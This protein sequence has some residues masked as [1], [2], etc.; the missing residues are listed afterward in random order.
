MWVLWGLTWGQGY[1]CPILVTNGSVANLQML[2]QLN[3]MLFVLDNVFPQT[4]DSKLPI[5]HEAPSCGFEHL[6][7]C[8]LGGQEEM[9]IKMQI[10]KMSKI[11]FSGLRILIRLIFWTTYF[12]ISPELLIV[13]V[14]PLVWSIFWP[15]F[16]ILVL[17][18][19]QRL[20]FDTR[21]IC[22]IG[23]TLGGAPGCRC[24]LGP[25]DVQ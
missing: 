22:A 3:L 9:P 25:W 14:D 5:L 4:R 12:F 15:S 8:G 18:G 16:R 21:K 11:H 7:V 10:L 20:L 23:C 6:N 13:F 24:W 17:L 1:T 19:I 2:A